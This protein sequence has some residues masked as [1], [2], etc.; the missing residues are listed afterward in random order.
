MQ[1]NASFTAFLVKAKCKQGGG[2][3][4][5]QLSGEV[6]MDLMPPHKILNGKPFARHQ[7]LDDGQLQARKQLAGMTI[8][9]RNFCIISM[10]ARALLRKLGDMF[11]RRLLA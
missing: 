4:A 10:R 9:H 2:V 5:V 8:R 3:V 11:D 7:G 6:R 1:G